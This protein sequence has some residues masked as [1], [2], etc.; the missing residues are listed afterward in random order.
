[1]NAAQK[2]FIGTAWLFLI[3]AGLLFL[4]PANFP[5]AQGAAWACLGLGI[6]SHVALLAAI[7]FDAFGSPPNSPPAE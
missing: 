2:V 3:L 1:M 7:V 6:A 4:V 5:S